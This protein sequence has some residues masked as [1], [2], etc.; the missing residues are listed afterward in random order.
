MTTGEIPSAGV[1]VTDAPN[2]WTCVRAIGDCLF[3]VPRGIV[4]AFSWFSNRRV[5]A[6][7]LSW[8]AM[9]WCRCNCPTQAKIG[10]EWA[11]HV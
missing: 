9:L 5:D 3:S 11:T 7:V 6:T 4:I 8:S 10:L 2:G 1:V